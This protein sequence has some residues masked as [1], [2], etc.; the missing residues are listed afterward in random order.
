MFVFAVMAAVGF[1]LEFIKTVWLDVYVSGHHP[2]FAALPV[3]WLLWN[4][5]PLT[6]FGIAKL[7]KER[8]D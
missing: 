3:F 1:N 4:L 2:D 8:G 7:L 6:I 5:F